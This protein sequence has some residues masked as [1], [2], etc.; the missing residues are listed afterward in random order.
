M[1]TSEEFKNGAALEIATNDADL[2]RGRSAI[3][4]LGTEVCFWRTDENA[5][6]SDEEG[7]AAEETHQPE[8]GQA[9]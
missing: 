8:P 6:S 2:V 4:V 9:V 7:L 5:S 1:T 3:A